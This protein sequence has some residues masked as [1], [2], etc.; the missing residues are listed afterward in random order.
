M[1]VP[2]IHVNGTSG[3]HLRVEW[4]TIAAQAMLLREMLEKAPVNAR[5]YYP[6]GP[7]AYDGA[8]KELLS[9]VYAVRN[10]ERELNELVFN[11]QNEMDAYAG[12][13]GI[14]RVRESEKKTIGFWLDDK[15]NVR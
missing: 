12:R 14:L 3:E 4:G 9:M 11:I 5:D 6:Q 8:Y 2:T 1:R 7:N 15:G 10:V 13:M